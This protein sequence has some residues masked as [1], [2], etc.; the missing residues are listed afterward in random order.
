MNSSKD[1]FREMIA[2]ALVK[3]AGELNPA[4]KEDTLRRSMIYLG[5]I[6]KRPE[7]QLTHQEE[8]APFC[9]P[10]FVEEKRPNGNPV[11]FRRKKSGIIIL[12]HES[13]ILARDWGMMSTNTQGAAY[14]D[15]TVERIDTE[16]FRESTP[17]LRLA[18]KKPW[19]RTVLIPRLAAHESDQAKQAEIVDT[20]ARTVA[21]QG[22]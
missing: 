13:L 22:R 1:D 15:M 14:Q 7:F 9:A 8:E 20:I 10:I 4:S 12:W 21:G 2:L 17:G 16:F 11:K 3:T 5:D 6:E 19:L 18:C